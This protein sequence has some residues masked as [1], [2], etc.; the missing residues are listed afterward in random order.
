[1]GVGYVSAHSGAYLF[2]AEYSMKAQY[3]LFEWKKKKGLL[4]KNIVNFTQRP[5]S[6]LYMYVSNEQK[7]QFPKKKN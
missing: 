3:Q 2:L 6:Y 1:M 7:E 4:N 5:W